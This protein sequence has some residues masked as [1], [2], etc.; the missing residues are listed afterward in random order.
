MGWR[1]VVR[2]QLVADFLF[3]LVAVGFFG[4][5]VLYIKGCER[6]VGDGDDG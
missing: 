4:L 2:T 3:V 6:I 5:C 1:G